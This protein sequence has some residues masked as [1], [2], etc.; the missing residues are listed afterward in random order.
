LR[1]QIVYGFSAAA[2]QNVA[3]QIG[4]RWRESTVAS[5]AAP[6]EPLRRELHLRIPKPTGTQRPQRRIRA[7]RTLSR[8]HTPTFRRRSATKTRLSNGAVEPDG[9]KATMRYTLLHIE[10][11]QRT[12]SYDRPRANSKAWKEYVTRRGVGAREAI[13]AKAS[14]RRGGMGFFS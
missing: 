13:G 11:V 10:Q 9:C 12:M 7:R 8:S 1:R 2:E 6:I 4:D 5:I 3:G 14:W